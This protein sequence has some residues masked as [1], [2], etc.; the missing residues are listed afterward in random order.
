MAAFTLHSE[1]NST[2]AS[3][4]WLFEFLSDFQNFERI[5][6]EDKVEG[7]TYSKEQCSFTIKG[8]TPMTVKLTD[9][10][11]F[12]FIL[13]SSDGLGKFNFELKA[14]FIGNSEE[15]GKCSVFL[16]GDLNPV[17][18]GFAKEPLQQLVNT[19]SKRLSEMDERKIA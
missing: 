14:N 8:I 12:E 7:F 2:K 18:L 10:K 1:E 19:M 15:Q 4:K 5:L 13:F 16:S 11:P 17:I 3:L 9:K 6:P